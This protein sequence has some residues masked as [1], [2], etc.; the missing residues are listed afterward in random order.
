M[1]LVQQMNIM[2]LYIHSLLTAWL[3][4]DHPLIDKTIFCIKCAS[5][6]HYS[7]NRCVITW[8]E[9][10]IEEKIYPV[11]LNCYRE[12]S[13]ENLLPYEDVKDWIL[14]G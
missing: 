14:N 2:K 4:K 9:I 11:C 8:I 6:V 10:T 5:V 12:H 1:P 7:S 3:R 13:S